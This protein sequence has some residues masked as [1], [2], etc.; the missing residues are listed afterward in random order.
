MSKNYVT[1]TTHRRAMPKRKFA[2]GGKSADSGRPDLD[3]LAKQGLSPSKAPGMPPRIFNE[4]LPPSGSEADTGGGESTVLERAS[5]DNPSLDRGRGSVLS[6]MMDRSADR[7]QRAH[8]N[9]RARA[10]L[11]AFYDMVEAR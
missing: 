3:I 4:Y 5:D 1:V 2:D 11:N 6:E 10:A 9:A 8:D 7:V